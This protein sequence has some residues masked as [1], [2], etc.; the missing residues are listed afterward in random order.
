MRWVEGERREVRRRGTNKPNESCR[1]E[2][3]VGSELLTAK[4]INPRNG[5]ET[6][7]GSKNG[8]S[9]REMLTELDASS[10]ASTKALASSLNDRMTSVRP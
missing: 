10:K 8:S 9:R 3:G 2:R 7:D 5:S 6:R 1:L 4:K